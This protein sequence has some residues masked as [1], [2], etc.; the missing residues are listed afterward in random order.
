[1]PFRNVFK[2]IFHYKA[3]YGAL[4]AWFVYV[5]EKSAFSES[6]SLMTYLGLVMYVIGITFNTYIYLIQRSL[7][8]AGTTKRQITSGYEF[9]YVTCPNYMF[10]TLNWLGVLLVS[11]N[12]SVLLSI[13]VAVEQMKAWAN[14]KEARYLFEFSGVYIPKKYGTIPGIL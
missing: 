11:R 9:S 7:R 10:Q 12:W 14:K 4:L 6:S 13:V 1:M 8:P 5:P 3:L 2:N